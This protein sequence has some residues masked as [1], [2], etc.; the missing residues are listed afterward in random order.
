MARIID[1]GGFNVM[2][3]QPSLDH[4]RRKVNTKIRQLQVQFPDNKEA[5]LQTKESVKALGVT[6]QTTYLY[7]QGHALFDNVVVPILNK[8]CNRLRQERQ[9]E[10]QRMA[11]HHTQRTNEMSCYEHSL[12]DIRQML[13][14][15][16]G[17]Q[18]SEPFARLLRDVER[19]LSAGT[20]DENR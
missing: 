4:L 12:Q 14:K 10:I 3:P 17:Y 15:N 5:Y 20:A 7:V 16:T 2:E 13:K 11:V 19:L 6:A 18:Q 9:D 8:V 1:P